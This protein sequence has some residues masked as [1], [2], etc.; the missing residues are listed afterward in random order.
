MR[1][2]S[3]GQLAACGLSLTAFFAPGPAV[4]AS[5]AQLSAAYCRGAANTDALAVPDSLA[6]AIASAFGV[7]EQA[8]KG[9]SY[10]R[11][12]GG[13]LLGCV[14]G[15][16]LPCGKV[17]VRRRLPGADDYC[18]QNPGS[19]FIPMAVTGHDTIYAW[20]CAAA[21]AAPGRPVVRLDGQGFVARDWKRL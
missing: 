21:A 12:A 13:R 1:V 17:D 10:Y 8:V 5:G 16:N 20:R 18:R 7:G 4:A 19:T 14:V 3:L 11:C 6:P 15:A 2:L 9:A